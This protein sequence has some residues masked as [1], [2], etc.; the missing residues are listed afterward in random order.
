MT[1]SRATSAAGLLACTILTMPS[2]PTAP[3]VSH[4]ISPP[5]T[6]R[7]CGDRWRSMATLTFG[8][9]GEGLGLLTASDSQDQASQRLAFPKWC[10]LLGARR[11]LPLPVGSG[12]WGKGTCQEGVPEEREEGKQGLGR[13]GTGFVLRVSVGWRGRKCQLRGFAQGAAAGASRAGS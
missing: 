8:C 7:V 9:R 10:G 4:G 2:S 5:L 11:A 1:V 3:Q 12:A 13:E 6:S